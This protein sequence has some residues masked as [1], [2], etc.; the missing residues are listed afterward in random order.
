ME[1]I[2]FI[3]LQASGKSTFY[4]QTFF[5][6]HLRINL[7]MLKR[8]SREEQFIQTCFD[9]QQSFVIDNTN[10]TKVSR[11]HYI[12]QAKQSKS[13]VIGYYFRA[14]VDRSLIWNSQREGKARVPDKAI[15]GSYKK[16]ELPS[17]S[18]GFDKLYYVSINELEQFVIEDW[19]DEV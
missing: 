6:T 11:F 13:D 10:L 1:M 16:L 8:R 4:K 15:L 19:Q 18:E 2:L 5:Y 3:G 7:D 17:Y 14:D 9:T 12:Q